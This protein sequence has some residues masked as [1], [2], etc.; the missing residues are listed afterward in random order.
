MRT[1]SAFAAIGAV[2]ALTTH[3]AK[4]AVINLFRIM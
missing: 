4:A 3:A 1:V 2:I